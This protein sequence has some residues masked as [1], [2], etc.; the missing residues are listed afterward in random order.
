LNVAGREQAIPHAPSG[1]TVVR[2]LGAHHR[3]L[4]AAG[5]WPV[6]HDRNAFA[7]MPFETKR[8]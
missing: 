7:G 2:V 6:Y 3:I 5:S 4:V 1:D 8:Q